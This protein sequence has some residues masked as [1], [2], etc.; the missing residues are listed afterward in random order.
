M[1]AYLAGPLFSDQDRAK[2]EEIAS[3]M[4]RL[5][6]RVYL[7]HRDGGDLGS[8]KIPY[9]KKNVRDRLFDRDVLEVRKCD[10]VVALLDGADVDSGTAVE[11][12]I[13]HALGIPVVGLKTDF[14]RRNRILNNMIWGVC[15]KGTR[16]SFDVEDLLRQVRAVVRGGASTRAKR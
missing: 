4:E 12:G 13:A 14:H 5:G 3:L 15:G 9:G 10:V 11:L 7:P 2:L 8:V 6:F 16:L 1:K